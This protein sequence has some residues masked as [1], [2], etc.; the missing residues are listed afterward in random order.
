M[1]ARRFRAPGRVN[2]IGEHTDY[3]EGFVMPAALEFETVVRITPRADRM[4]TLRSQQFVEPVEFSLDAAEPQARHAW[5]DYVQGV[6]IAIEQAG[7]RLTGADLSIDSNV[8]VGAGLSSSAA[9][10]VS[11]A[12]ALST[13]SGHSIDRAELARLCQQ[14]ENEFVGMKCGIMDQFI[15]IHGKE[16][17]A[18]LLGQQ[19]QLIRR[20]GR[21]VRP[22]G[23]VLLRR[24]H[25]P[26]PPG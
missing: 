25:P 23:R 1:T 21:L 17:H 6:A 24:D 10:E 9:L 7:Y 26:A 20:V 2:L 13:V 16:D 4:V 15:S 19:A 8:P 22:L 18:I 12:M 14:A 11:A 3:N 5:S